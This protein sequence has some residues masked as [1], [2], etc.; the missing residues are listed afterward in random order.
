MQVILTLIRRCSRRQPGGTRRLM[1]I[2]AVS[3]ERTRKRSRR[4]HR[5]P[6]L[7][8]HRAPPAFRRGPRSPLHRRIP[9][10]QS[11]DHAGDAGGEAE[12]QHAAARLGAAGGYLAAAAAGGDRQRGRPVL[13]ALGRRLGR[14]ARGGQGRRRAQRAARRQ[15]HPDADGQES[16]SVERPELSSARRSKCRSLMSCRRSG[17]SSG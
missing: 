3:G 12:G 13:R 7:T 1:A 15:H 8:A 4:H 6:W 14:G 5:H 10:R 2:Q 9:L 17:R 16:L 11:A